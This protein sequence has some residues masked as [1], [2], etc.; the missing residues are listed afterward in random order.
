[1]FEDVVESSKGIPVQVLNV[2]AG[3]VHEDDM[4]NRPMLR[5]LQGMLTDDLHAHECTTSSPLVDARGRQHRCDTVITKSRSLSWPHVVT[6]IEGKLDLE[7]Q[8]LKSAIGQCQRRGVAILEQQPWRDIVIL[9]FHCIRKIGFLQVQKPATPSVSTVLGFVNVED[10][11]VE[12]GQGF[13]TLCHLIEREFGWVPCPLLLHLNSAA[14]LAEFN[15]ASVL[16]GR[17]S[18]KTVFLLSDE[19]GSKRVLKTAVNSER[20]LHECAVLEALSSVPGVLKVSSLFL[21]EVS[22]GLD[23]HKRS[24]FLMNCCN[25]VTPYNARPKH[26]ADFA[27]TLSKAAELNIHHNDLSLD[28]MVLLDGPDGQGVII[29]WEHATK[30]QHV[31]TGFSGK[32]AFASDAALHLRE[33]GQGRRTACLADDLESLFYVA[34]CCGLQEKLEWPSIKDVQK[35]MRKRKEECCLDHQKLRNRVFLY[36]ADAQWTVIWHKYLENVRQAMIRMIRAPDYEKDS[37]VQ[38]VLQAWY[39]IDTNTVE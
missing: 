25:A 16:C 24:A 30:D 29:D 36:G 15:H 21:V 4:I 2:D 35:L 5:L 14:Q 37:A 8:S 28:N 13:H 38:V 6:A 32:L 22:N 19:C 9:A 33:R 18:G 31:V 12:K 10:G 34:V 20:L 23:R 3:S 1:V 17:T 26:F 39:Q 7:N 11:Q 27:R